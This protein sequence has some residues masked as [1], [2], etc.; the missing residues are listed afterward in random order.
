MK[1][2]LTLAGI[3]YF[4]A[5]TA[6]A[7][8]MTLKEIEHELSATYSKIFPFYYSNADSLNFYSDQFNNKFTTYISNY[9]ATLA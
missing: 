8:T 5:V 4:L 9:P 7:Q 6:A 2:Y 3:L 1:K